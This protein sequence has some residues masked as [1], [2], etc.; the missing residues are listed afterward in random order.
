MSIEIVRNYLIKFH[1]EQDIIELTQSSATVALAAE[2]LGI[3]EARIAKTLAFQVNNQAIVIVCAG[4]CK[5]DNHHFKETF[6]VKAKMLKIEDVESYTNHKVGGVCPF[7]IPE[8]THIYLDESLKRFES[9]FPACGSSNSCIQLTI[10][11][12]EELVPYVCWVDVCKGWQTIE[13]KKD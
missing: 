10:S 4:D 1:R 6:Q 13:E 7:G 8:T 12:L 11:D 9:V 5:I 3:I 2:A